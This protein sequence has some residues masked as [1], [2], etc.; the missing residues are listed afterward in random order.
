MRSGHNRSYCPFFLLEKRR[1]WVQ[2]SWIDA[3][4]IRV[5]PKCRDMGGLAYSYHG[6]GGRK[7]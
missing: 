1:K 6:A 4:L 5:A 2:I 3:N 7:A